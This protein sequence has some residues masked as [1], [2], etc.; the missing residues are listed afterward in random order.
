MDVKDAFI[1]DFD[2]FLSVLCTDY[3]AIQFYHIGFM[4]SFKTQ[5]ARLARFANH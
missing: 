4:A 3:M 1:G 5:M 2:F